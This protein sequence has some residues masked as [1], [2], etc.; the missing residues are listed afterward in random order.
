MVRRIKKL[1]ITIFTSETAPA[2]AGDGLNALLLA[3][4]LIKKGYSAQLI[5]L[6][7]N[8]L[9]PK[10]EVINGVTIRRIAYH[11]KNK[12]GRLWL[13]VNMLLY[14]LGAARKQGYWLI[15]GAMPA[16]RLLVLT[17]WILGKK[18]FFRSTLYSFDDASTLISSKKNPVKAIFR[19]I[20][21]RVAGYH[22][23]N[24]VFAEA[25]RKTY[26]EII[27]IFVSPQGTTIPYPAPNIQNRKTARS[28]LGLPPDPIIVL[29]VGHLITRKGFP[30]IFEWLAKANC[31]FLL[32]HVGTIHAP[33]SNIISIRNNEMRQNIVAGQNLLGE[34]VKFMEC[35]QRPSLYYYAADI[36]LLASAA[37]G[38]PPNTVNEAMAAGLPILSNRIAGSTDYI[39]DNHNGFL[40]TGFD[41]FI[42]RFS[43][44]VSNQDI[45][46]QLGNNARLYA[47]KYLDVNPIA[48]NLLKFMDESAARHSRHSH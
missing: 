12:R 1:P 38:Y 16:N 37:E 48:E 39:S 3:E 22:A 4:S 19:F 35:S 26:N 13:R 41:E 33:E 9:L 42:S 24:S 23:L 11:Y 44:L 36:L 40:Y 30:D 15:Y 5:C 6:N 10:S 8:K 43:Q 29:M 32:L 21:G 20:Y 2:F 14:I 7:P 45:R 18:V 17:G 25:W 27:P 46:Q 47:E 28:E 31:S 34:R